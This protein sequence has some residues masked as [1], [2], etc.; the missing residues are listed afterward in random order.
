MQPVI[1]YRQF[2]NNENEYQYANKHFIV[3]K[4]RA[5][6]WLNKSLVIGRYSVL[7]FYEELE[8]DLGIK[9]CKLINSYQQHRYVADIYQWYEDLKDITPQTWRFGDGIDY[10]NCA[11]SQ[12]ILKGETNSRK[13]LW[14]THMFAKDVSEITDIACRLMDD[15]LICDQDIYVRKYV[16]LKSYDVYSVNDLP[17][18]HEFRFFVAYGQILSGGYY[19]SSHHEE[20]IERG[21]NLDPDQVPREFLQ[22]AIDKIG[23]KCNFYAIDVALTKENEWIVIELNDGQMSGLSENDPDIM[24]QNLRRMVDEQISKNN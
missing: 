21:A 11:P 20:L 22:K 7:P 5:K 4:S 17:V 10:T 23:N 24:Y 6:H 13:F 14:H 3:S 2:A 12:Y 9:N 15:S 16:P 8:N 19:W 18:T 1:L